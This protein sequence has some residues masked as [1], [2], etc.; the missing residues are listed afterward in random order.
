MARELDFIAEA[1]N[2]EKCA[3]DLS[4]L[5]FIYVPKVDWKLT[6]QVNSDIYIALLFVLLYGKSVGV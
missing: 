5:S 6:T 3:S 1:E 4:H 2:A